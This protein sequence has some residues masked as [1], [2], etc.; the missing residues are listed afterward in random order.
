[1]RV[2]GVPLKDTSFIPLIRPNFRGTAIK[3]LKLMTTLVPI[4]VHLL[5]DVC[6]SPVCTV[7]YLFIYFSGQS[8]VLLGHKKEFQNEQ[9]LQF[10][11]N[12][13][14]HETS[15]ESLSLVPKSWNVLTR[16]SYFWLGPSCVCKNRTPPQSSVQFFSFSLMIFLDSGLCSQEDMFSMDITKLFC[17]SLWN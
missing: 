4:W 11:V 1:M 12:K 17:T 15:L 14:K 2:K 3:H 16:I 10:D 8:K 9:Q 5:L 13:T 6:I 7:L